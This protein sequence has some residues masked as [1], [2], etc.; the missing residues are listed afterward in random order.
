NDGY[1]LG[2]NDN[3]QIVGSRFNDNRFGGYV[4]EKN[5]GGINLDFFPSGFNNLGQVVGQSSDK[6]Y[7]WD[8][9]T[10]AVDLDQVFSSFG[11]SIE[12]NLGEDGRGSLRINDAGQILGTGFFNGER[13]AF[14][15]TPDSSP[16]KS[17]PEPA[18]A[19]GLLAFGAFGA[20]SLGKRQRQQHKQFQIHST[21][22]KTGT[23]Q[24]VSI[25]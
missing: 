3:G 24:M 6:A 20:A 16:S 22:K 7:L 12:Y 2:I 4:W 17:V 10:G 14:L 9:N 5:T 15:L 1:T 13:R 11:C 19:L 18:T 25:A 8:K 23:L 21:G